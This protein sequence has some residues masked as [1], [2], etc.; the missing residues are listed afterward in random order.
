MDKILV[1]GASGFV[2]SHWFESSRLRDQSTS[3]SLQ[4]R[5]IGS[6]SLEGVA[7]VVHMAGIAHRMAEPSGNIYYEVNRDLTLAFAQHA[8]S[9]GVRH[10]VYLSSTKVMGEEGG[11]F[12]EHARPAPIDDY[13]KSKWEAEVGLSGMSSSHFTVSVIRPPL[14]YGPRVKGNVLRIMNMLTRSW[15]VP[16]GGISNC[17]SMVS[18]SNLI[19]LIERIIELRAGGVFIAGD[20]MPI[21]TTQLV[22]G[23]AQGM[24]SPPRIVSLPKWLQVGVG[25]AFP[26]LGRR[27]F[28]SYVVSN[29]AT[30]DQL[31]FTPPIET[32]AA[33]TETARWY[34]KNSIR[35]KEVT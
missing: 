15:P 24:P 32:S 22:L 1:T 6:I 28:G 30:N 31:A 16:L 10:F 4:N 9:A 34:V 35:K 7:V 23:L 8:R 17:R 2:G 27:L 29:K 20:R 25:R 21:S 13:G 18:V 26:K 5:S 19:A 11:Y 14:I 33:L 3:L 12:D